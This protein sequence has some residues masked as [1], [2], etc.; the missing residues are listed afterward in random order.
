MVVSI[1]KIENDFWH[2]PLSRTKPQ[3]IVGIIKIIREGYPDFTQFDPEHSGYDPRSQK[4]NP[5]WFMVDVQ[6][7]RDI[8]PPITRKEL[9]QH[10][11]LAE[12]VLFRN[13]RLSVQPVTQAEAE[14]ILSLRPED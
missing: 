9:Q 3:A 2:V 7:Y 12:M 6:Y 1:R 5:R 8:T 4:D 14:L 11:V 10:P 13:T